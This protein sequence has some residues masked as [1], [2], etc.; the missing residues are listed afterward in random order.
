MRDVILALVRMPRAEY[1]LMGLKKLME[2]NREAV[3][4]VFSGL[5]QPEVYR[6]VERHKYAMGLTPE[7]PAGSAKSNWMTL[8][9]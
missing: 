4:K 7:G 5:D 2:M 6:F 9:K 8:W 1:A 3:K